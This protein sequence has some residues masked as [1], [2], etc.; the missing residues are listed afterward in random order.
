[1]LFGCAQFGQRWL[2][3][4]HPFEAIAAILLGHIRGVMLAHNRALA[5]FPRRATLIGHVPLLVGM[6]GYIVGALLLLFSE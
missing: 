6:V 4:A 3:A 5:L 2:G 1:M